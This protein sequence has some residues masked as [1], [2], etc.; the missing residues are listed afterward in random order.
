MAVF[1]PGRIET[2]ICEPP[3]V[4]EVGRPEGRAVFDPPPIETYCEPPEICARLYFYDADGEELGSVLG[5]NKTMKVKS[6]AKV[7][8]I[9]TGGSY[10]FFK[11]KKHKGG[12][13]CI[14]YNDMIDLKEETDYE[15]TVVR[16]VLYD[17]SKCPKMA[18]VPLWTIAAAIGVV[19]LI[20]VVAVM[21]RGKRSQEDPASSKA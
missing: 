10:T 20:A 18:G 17:H 19:V 3:E 13:V 12:S 9:G 4:C 8:Q 2:L 11:R 14:D 6:V 7:Q 1:D 15:A 21:L 5:T 16:S